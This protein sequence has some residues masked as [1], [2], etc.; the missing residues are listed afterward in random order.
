MAFPIDNPNHSAEPG[1]RLREHGSSRQ[2]FVEGRP[3][4]ILG[5]EAHNSSSSSLAYM[6]HVWDR[7]TAL[8]LNTVLAPICW[9]QLE[10][11]EG[12]FDFTLV[13]GLLAEICRA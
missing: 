9:E 11:V 6:E 13:N 5:G 1:I 2:L 12:E 3:F 7:A 8:N 10:P 4:L